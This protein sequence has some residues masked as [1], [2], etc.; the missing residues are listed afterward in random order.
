MITLV[1]RCR[2][3]G[4]V[5]RWAAFGLAP[6]ALGLLARC[7][8]LSLSLGSG[9]SWAASIVWRMSCAY[10]LP[11]LRLSLGALLALLGRWPAGHYCVLR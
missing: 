8:S 6:A 9:P 5:I 10:A 3:C 2:A 1:V 4:W 11:P 7:F